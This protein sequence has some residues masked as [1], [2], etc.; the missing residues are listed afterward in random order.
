[1]ALCTSRYWPPILP[2]RDQ[3]ASLIFLTSQLEKLALVRQSR[4]V[5]GGVPL[6]GALL[7]LLPWQQSASASASECAG[8]TIS[9]L[10]GKPE[11]AGVCWSSATSGCKDCL[12]LGLLP[13]EGVLMPSAPPP[14]PLLC[15]VLAL[16]PTQH[17][18]AA[19]CERNCEPPWFSVGGRHEGQL[20][21]A[22][23]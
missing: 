19:L 6:R 21:G 12:V 15:L 13:W 9:V 5:C 4:E 22:P 17:V 18:G 10:S 2:W 8:K 16:D 11:G 1:M 20:R 14:R 23:G 3:C 7:C